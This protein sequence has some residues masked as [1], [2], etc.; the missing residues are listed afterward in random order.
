MNEI[1][2]YI[3]AKALSN[4]TLGL[5]LNPRWVKLK[6]ENPEIEDNDTTYF[7]T[8]SALD[9]LL[10]S[11][12][13]WD[14]DFKVISVSRPWGL[15][16]KFI[17]NLPPNLDMFS[18]AEHYQEAYDKSGYKMKLETV[19]NNFWK[20]EETYK[21]Y[22]ATRGTDKEKIIV[23]KDEYE[24]V[25]KCKELILANEFIEQYFVAKGIGQEILRQ[26]PIYFRYMEEDCKA[27]LDG[28][29]ID[30]RQRTIQPYDLKTTGKSVYDF[31][32]SYLQYGYYRQG[33][34]YTHAICSETSPVYQY[35]SEGYTLLDFIFIVVET[36]LSSSHPAV[37]FRTAPRDRECGLSGGYIGKRYYKGINDLIAD[38]KFYKSNDY[39]D[40]PRDLYENKGEILLNEFND[41]N[42]EDSEEHVIPDIY[43]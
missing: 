22:M 31:P 40:L 6:L 19:I 42:E 17:D 36:K 4:S 11:P 14:E 2:E 10:T 15:M 3:S 37:I 27:L 38:Y 18:S 39:W 30:H 29:L 9:C 34:F 8:G 35:L 24:T 20:N 7:R 28:V 12:E 23:S 32:K 33:A 43:S 41:D 26:V 16:G 1:K 13:R 5:M 25:L 21:Y